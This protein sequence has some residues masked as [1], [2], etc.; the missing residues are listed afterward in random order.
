MPEAIDDLAAGL[1]SPAL[2]ALTRADITQREQLTQV[3]E[4]ELHRLHGMGAEAIGSFG[5]RSMLAAKDW[6]SKL[7]DGRRTNVSSC[8]PGAA[9]T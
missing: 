1:S 9:L 8:G 3:R 4:S 2:R 6:L 5:S 7:T